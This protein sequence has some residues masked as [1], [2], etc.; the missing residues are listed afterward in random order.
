VT[1]DLHTH[2]TASDGAYSPS[3]LVRLAQA[4]GVTHLALTDHDCTN[5]LIEAQAEAQACGLTLIRAVEI[6]TTWHGKSVHVVGLDIDPA[7]ATL[8]Q[9]LARL[10]TL[11]VSRAEEM[12]RRLAKAGIPGGFEAAQAL[13]GERGMIT[14]THFAQFLA[15]QG[16]AGTVRDV[17]DHY[18][19]QGKPGYVPTVWA[20]L[21]EAVGWI[22]AAGGVAVVAHPQRYKLTANWLGR[23]LR[24]F[25]E[26][27]GE[28]L[29]VIAG[30]SSIGDIQS[31]SS[32]ARRHGLLASVG[33]DFHS[34]ENVWLK[35][36]RL[37]EL[38][39]DLTPVWSL[40]HD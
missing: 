39:P 2:S 32:A 27:G 7:C 37:P 28:A 38:P 21:G 31:S 17:F 10:Q 33:S 20:G 23:L 18:L 35:L 25:K 26:A 1:Y 34:P 19:V 40:W 4:A 36:G 3:K 11:R 12:G 24:E 8:Q 29:E 5:G 13:A 14:R 15:T 30:C 9:G 22:K 16:L 6:S